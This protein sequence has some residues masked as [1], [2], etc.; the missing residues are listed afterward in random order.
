MPTKKTDKQQ[1]AEQV[2]VEARPR[3]LIS[4]PDEPVLLELSEDGH[5]VIIKQDGYC[6]YLSPDMAL[7]MIEPLRVLAEQAKRAEGGAA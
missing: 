4:G 6:V 3:Y 5:E 2:T 7:A 1:D